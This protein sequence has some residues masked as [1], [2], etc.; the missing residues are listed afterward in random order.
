[1]C[2]SVL[3][4]GSL[5]LA[6]GALSFCVECFVENIVAYLNFKIPRKFEFLRW[7]GGCGRG[8][9]PEACEKLM[10]LGTWNLGT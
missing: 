4:R 8:A 1:M 6:T 10:F 3:L 2:G 7:G 9:L 5:T